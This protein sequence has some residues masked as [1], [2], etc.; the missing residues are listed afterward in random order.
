MLYN[1]KWLQPG[2]IFPPIKEA[3]RIDRYYQNAQL[4]DGD[5]FAS[6]EFRTHD[7]HIV[8][9]VNLYLKCAQRISQVIGNFD[10]VVSFP[11][12]LNYQRLMSLKM[13]D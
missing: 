1:F 4:F 6:P 3:P 8:G 9:G 7:D 11:T 12:L 10:E 5:H 13:A 2:Q